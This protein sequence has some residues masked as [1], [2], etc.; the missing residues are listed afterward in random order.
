[1]PIDELLAIM[2]RLRD[3]QHGCPW[4]VEQ[5][6]ATIAPYTIEEAYEVADAI[7]REDHEALRDELG[8]LLFQVAFH[9]QMAQEAGAFGFGDVVASICDK[10]R[11][12]HPH[13][14]GDAHVADAA[15]QARAWEE[16]K[17]RERA[18][19]ARGGA[20]E[21][22]PLALPALTRAAKLGKRAARV[23]FDWPDTA[24]ARAKIDEELRELDE[25][26]TDPPPAITSGGAAARRSQEIGDI[27]FSV[28]NLARHLDVDPEAALR[29]ANDRFAGRFRSMEQQAG[30]RGVG[31]AQL[32]AAA[33]D[34]L[35]RRAKAAAP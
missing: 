25:E 18:A 26:I 1:M 17:A 11:R 19:S 16:H 8:D 31:L 22:V 3:P 15:Q 24:G 23:G 20:L 2:K 32:D 5:S 34:E 4:D 10:M 14:F 29:A 21:D 9:A 27:L 12:R 6:F 28:V 30:S 13:V 33:L 7:A 35:W